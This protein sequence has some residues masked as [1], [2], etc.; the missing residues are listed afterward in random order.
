MIMV[1]LTTFLVCQ[2]CAARGKAVWLRDGPGY[3]HEGLAD[4]SPGFRYIDRGRI[5][6][7]HFICTTCNS[8]VQES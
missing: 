1:P 8:K 4:L 2:M 6:G 3:R 5:F 7:S